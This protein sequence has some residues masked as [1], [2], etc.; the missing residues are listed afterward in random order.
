MDNTTMRSANAQ[1]AIELLKQTFLNVLQEAKDNGEPL[2][3]TSEITKRLDITTKHDNAIAKAI[4][5][6][7]QDE[8]LVECILSGITKYKLSDR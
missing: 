3:S 8:K 2:L 7:L 5:S 4:L 1:T 6:T